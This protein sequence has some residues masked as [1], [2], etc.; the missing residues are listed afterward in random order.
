MEGSRGRR[1]LATP[2]PLKRLF[3]DWT[4]DRADATLH[5]EVDAFVGEAEPNVPDR[6]DVPAPV[7]QEPGVQPGGYQW[8]EEA[9]TAGRGEGSSSTTSG[10][11]SSSGLRQRVVDSSLVGERTGEG[12]LE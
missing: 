4:R 10:T 7:P 11:P 2:L 3:E 8:G 12:A 5:D 9:G 6:A 1:L